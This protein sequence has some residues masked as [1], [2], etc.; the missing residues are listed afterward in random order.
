MA[1]TPPQPLCRHNLMDIADS[2]FDIFPLEELSLVGNNT[3]PPTE[4]DSH[5]DR[6]RTSSAR[7][8][9][10]ISKAPKKSILKS[11]RTFRILSLI[12]HCALVGIHFALMVVWAMGMEHRLEVSQDHARIIS[13]LVTAITTTFGTIYLALLVFITQNMSMRHDLHT[14]QSLTATHDNATAWAGL[15]SALSCIWRQRTVPASVRGVL[16]ALIYLGSIA[17]LHVTLPNMFFLQTVEILHPVVVGTRGLPSYPWHLG[18]PPCRPMSNGVQ[19]LPAILGNIRR[20]GLH[21]GSL[22]D[23]LDDNTGTGKATVDATGFNIT[24]RSLP[25]ARIVPDILV[26]NGEGRTVMLDSTDKI[27]GA[28]PVTPSNIIARFQ[29]IIKESYAT[30]YTTPDSMFIYATVPIID[31]SGAS[32]PWVEFPQPA[33]VFR[34]FQSLVKQTAV[35]DVES[36]EVLEILPKILK[37]SSTW[38]P[39]EPGLDIPTSGNPLIDNWG[40]WFNQIPASEFAQ[41]TTLAVQYR[42]YLSVA[43]LYLMQRFNLAAAE[44]S[45]RHSNVAL[46]DLEN[47]LSSIAA[48]VFW[49]MGHV[50]HGHGFRYIESKFQRV[51]LPPPPVHP[52][53]LKGN[54]TVSEIVTE[55]RLTLNVVAVVVGL[56]ATIVLGLVSLQY[57]FFH[58]IPRDRNDLVINGTGILHTIWL[59][60][61]QPEFQT[62]LKQVGTPTTNNL[63]EAGM[64]DTTFGGRLPGAEPS[65]LIDFNTDA[66]LLRGEST[67]GSAVDANANQ[68]NSARTGLRVQKTSVLSSRSLQFLSLFLHLTLV[69]IHLGLVWICVLGPEHRLVVSLAHQGIASFLVTVMTTTFTTIY[70]ALLVLNTQ[71]L[72]MRRDLGIHQTLTA[73]HDNTAAWAGLGSAVFYIW[74][75]R[76]VSA[77]LKRVLLAFFYLG[78]I[79]LLQLAMSSMFAMQTVTVPHSGPIV[80]QSLPSYPLSHIGNGSRPS[81][82]W[83]AFARGALHSLPL[84]LNNSSTKGL[85]NGTL[86]DVPRT[87][88]VTTGNITVNATGFN[89]TCRFLPEARTIHGTI[90]GMPYVPWKVELD[91]KHQVFGRIRSAARNIISHFNLMDDDSNSGS[92]LIYAT[93]PI[94][95]SQG[96]IGPSV[97][98]TR[99]YRNE[100]S[101]TEP[102]W[103]RPLL[104]F[105]QPV[106]LFQCSQLLVNQT[107][108]IDAESHKVLDMQPSVHKTS[109][110][111]FPSAPLRPV[112]NG[113]MTGNS[114][115]DAWA[116][117]YDAMPNS[118]FPRVEPYT[119]QNR[120]DVSVAD[121]YLIQ[122]FNLCAVKDTQRPSNVTLHDLENALSTIVAAMF[123]TLGHVLPLHGLIVEREDEQVLNAPVGGPILLEGVATV[124]DMVTE[125]RL[126]LNIIS[127]LVGLTASIALF[128]IS[129]QYSVYHGVPK[130]AEDVTVVGVGILHTIWLYRNQ[131]ELERLLKQVEYPTN[132]NLRKGG[133]VD[134]TFGGQLRKPRDGVS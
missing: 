92:L 53:L 113:S 65:D 89:I 88:A 8:K 104:T 30:Y 93:L 106:Q 36:R 10:Q 83:I 43:D 46:H 119:V 82:P 25:K 9:L 103:N 122:R 69:V 67:T 86:Y 59:Y 79:A 11:S 85:Y 28:V 130:H 91:S 48:T 42:N 3:T 63:R 32:A 81:D 99:P 78:N 33:Q 17:I 71:T 13:L 68:L 100:S 20:E 75:Q 118:Y 26:K 31:S 5:S 6:D 110:T 105:T 134:T 37:T 52:I 7:T 14:H 1:D 102:F 124:R 117:W 54:A 101:S 24:C 47:V 128:W 40:C 55:T 109:S 19:M 66:L 58:K 62:V 90:P 38:S 96:N 123:W 120:D 23:I 133:M 107:A 2:E 95:D 131:P 111:W 94:V 80:T 112:P 70:S 50:L 114:F 84:I 73:A 57:S 132:K 49:T 97:N 127:V 45:E 44:V 72:S 21:E 51:I 61:N 115:I 56:T 98:F 22:Y 116:Q 74:N 121:L 60:R 29:P 76:D 34:C 41:T 16:L 125:A 64:V 39:F 12:L 126:D 15:G 108:V 18:P 129:L 4:D 27:M 35:I 77:S 87:N